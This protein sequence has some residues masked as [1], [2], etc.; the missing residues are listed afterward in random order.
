ML[1]RNQRPRTVFVPLLRGHLNVGDFVHVKEVQGRDAGEHKVYRI[2]RFSA[3]SPEFDGEYWERPSFAGSS[4]TEHDFDAEGYEGHME[5]PEIVLTPETWTLPLNLV[6]SDPVFAFHWTQLRD[7]E[8]TPVDVRGA[9]AFG[10]KIRMSGKRG[11]TSIA[12]KATDVPAFMQKSEIQRKYGITTRS[13]RVWGCYRLVADVIQTILQRGKAGEFTDSEMVQG[14]TD[15]QWALLCSLSKKAPKTATSTEAATKKVI[16]TADLV[17]FKRARIMQSEKLNFCSKLEL[18]QLTTAFGRF[19]NIAL[20]SSKIRQMTDKLRL[21]EGVAIKA[22]HPEMHAAEL[23]AA[24]HDASTYR[25]RK[26]KDA[27]GEEK[28][29][30][31]CRKA[32]VF[33]NFCKQK[34]QCSGTLT[35]SCSWHEK[36]FMAMGWD[37]S[38]KGALMV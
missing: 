18:H 8:A 14:F 21:S 26:S 2:L 22:I 6:T 23:Q 34:G 31:D 32:G 33:F 38:V 11:W 17:V 25:K 16:I 27:D 9:Y 5:L 29:G 3:D 28:V 30:G 7:H 24:G 1:A 12:L 20:S 37:K 35:I 19:W 10:R 13:Q 15:E 36:V 4:L